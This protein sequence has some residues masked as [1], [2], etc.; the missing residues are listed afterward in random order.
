MSETAVRKILVWHGSSFVGRAMKFPFFFSY[1]HE[2]SSRALQ[3]CLIAC[4]AASGATGAHAQVKSAVSVGLTA[5]KV[6]AADGK[7]SLVP[8]E[9]AKPGDVI[10]Y[11]AVY[12]NNSNAAVHNLLATVPVPNGLAFSPDSVKPAGALA[13]VDGKN[14]E[15]IPLL[16][17][18]TK[19]DGTREKQPVPLSEYRSLRWSISELAPGASVTVSARARV[20][21]K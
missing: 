12:Q 20:I 8:A 19:A 1:F 17:T 21:S 2:L 10:E 9:H 16:R 3:I 11:D 6:T 5:K 13:S 18:V 7:E 4:L 14:F 15:P